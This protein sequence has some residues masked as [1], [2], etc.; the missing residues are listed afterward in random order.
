MAV[1]SAL[2]DREVREDCFE[3]IAGAIHRRRRNPPSPDWSLAL[4]VF[5]ITE[6]R[7]A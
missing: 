7:E 5:L 1:F 6:A 3:R 2:P 4:V